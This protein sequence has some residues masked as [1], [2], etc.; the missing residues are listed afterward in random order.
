MSF[1]SFT[2]HSVQLNGSNSFTAHI[3]IEFIILQKTKASWAN[4]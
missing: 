3:Y 1:F 4:L 2:G